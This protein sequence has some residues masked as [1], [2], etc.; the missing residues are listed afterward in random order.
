MQLYLGAIR[1]EEHR[2]AGD[3]GVV[4]HA[5]GCRQRP[6]EV[7]KLSGNPLAGDRL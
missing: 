5:A 7:V 6:T 3:L 1:P 4:I 2:T